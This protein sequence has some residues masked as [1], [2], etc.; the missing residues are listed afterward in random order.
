MCHR[1]TYLKITLQYN[2]CISF[3][4][5]LYTMG[6]CRKF[7]CKYSWSNSTWYQII[8]SKP[9]SYWNYYYIKV[10]C[11]LYRLA[12]LSFALSWRM[13]CSTSMA[14]TSRPLITR[15]CREARSSSVWLRLRIIMRRWWTPSSTQCLVCGLITVGL[16]SGLMSRA[17]FVKH[18]HKTCERR[19]WIPIFLIV[20][21]YTLIY[22]LIVYM[23]LNCFFFVMKI[24]M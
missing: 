22:I 1:N 9:S 16:H 10:H 5:R 21:S 11:V 12:T 18:V 13:S 7:Y 3:L 4:V 24:N 20:P 15:P 17:W 8:S 23:L 2:W 19:L 14:S 6:H